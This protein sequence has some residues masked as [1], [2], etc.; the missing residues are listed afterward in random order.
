M[1]S[2]DKNQPPVNVFTES[3]ANKLHHC[4]NKNS[5]ISFTE[6][7]KQNLLQYRSGNN[8]QQCVSQPN[9]LANAQSQFISSVT[10]LGPSTF[11]LSHPF[12][13]SI[14]HMLSNPTVHQKSLNGI[15]VNNS[16]IT[17]VPAVATTSTNFN[18]TPL[19]PCFNGS[20]SSNYKTQHQPISSLSNS[21]LT[22]KLTKNRSSHESSNIVPEPQQ[23]TR[24]E[25]EKC[26]LIF[27]HLNDL[28]AHVIEHINSQ[29]EFCCKWDGCEREQPF[30][31]HYML[32]LHVRR[33]TGE[34]PH[35]CKVFI[36]YTAKCCIL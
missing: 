10:P 14:S 25:W 29:E 22:K 5:N 7:Q 31:A 15:M 26:S 33:H 3:A 36:F 18:A 34:K 30:S 16:G 9:Q 28:V 24:C 21:Q 20:S 19:I 32:T 17:V 27:P 1:N 23:V 12:S 6:Q 4:D 35:V 2:N 13:Q 8:Y 11:N